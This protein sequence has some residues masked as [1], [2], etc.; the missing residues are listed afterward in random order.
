MPRIIAVLLLS[1]VFHACKTSPK[2]V[3]PTGLVVENA[4]VVAAREEAA[5]I[6]VEIMQKGG[7]A[8]D[9]MVATEMALA[10][11]YPFAGNL[12]GGG[13][14][15]YRKAD[16]TVGALDYR[17]KAPLAA[18]KDMYL[19]SVG[20]VVPDMSTLG[21]TAVGV[22]GTVAG[23]IA[24]HEKFG[25]L[26][27]KEIFEP[28]IALANKGVIVTKKQAKRLENTRKQFIA[29]NGDSTKFASIFKV[30]DTIKYPALA[31]TLTKIQKEGKAGFYK[32]E[33]AEKLAN[34]IQ[35]NGGYITTED[36]AKY[37][38]KWRNPIVFNYKDLKI[39]SMS[40]PSS[41]GIT[42]N[43]I[44]KM[45]EDHDIKAYGHNSTKNIQLFT[46]AARR[47]YADRNY[48]LGDPDFVTIPTQEMTSENYLKKRMANF[49]FDKATPSD[50][51]SRGNIKIIESDETTHYSIVDTE[52]NAVSVTTT[53]NGAY[54][55]KLYS[56]ELGFFLNNEMDDFSA[57]PGIPNMFG[58]IGAEANSIAPEKRMLS[59]MSPTIVEKDGNLYMVVGTPGGSTIIT[60]VAQTILNVYE[61]ELSMQE[62]VNAPRFHHQWLPD[63][64]M[65]EEEG[66][67]NELKAQ[68]KSKGYSIL[69]GR[70]R[71]IG[72]VDAI[73]VLP[74]GKLEGGADKR[75]DDKAVGF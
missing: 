17:E 3:A 24:A 65:F 70:T 14:M 40:P 73:K 18:H 50:S 56:D 35:N 71:I 22:P 30:G 61:H 45:M 28:V 15:V 19:D 57:K 4:M 2:H 69:E 29:V 34:F 36:L 42:M 67:S 68:L 58:L 64:I 46:E 16:G 5:Q 13:F 8:F 39:I 11:A 32:G 62:A 55:S 63:M 1:L 49:S 51:I 33:I 53:L 54:G 47:A 27:L 44:F 43:Q 25:K 59:S 38:A 23:V 20:N 41:G 9:A 48:F 6:G 74:N 75:G 31:A 60:A 10:I 21:A 72:K 7:N 66:F 26:S 52:G 12:G 37:E